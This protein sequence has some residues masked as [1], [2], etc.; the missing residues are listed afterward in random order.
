VI[1][2]AASLI[3]FEALVD[4]GGTPTDQSDDGFLGDVVIKDVGNPADFCATI[5]RAIG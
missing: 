4:N 2:R 3:R 5:I 1:A